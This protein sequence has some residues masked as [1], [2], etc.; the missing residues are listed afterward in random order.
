MSSPIAWYVF[1]HPINHLRRILASEKTYQAIGLDI[2]SHGQPDLFS[3]YYQGI[4]EV[5][6]P[7]A[8][9]MPPKMDIVSPEE[10]A[11]YSDVVARYYRYQDRLLGDVLA[12][13]S[14]DTIVIV[15]SDHGFQN[16]SGRP[17]QAPDIENSPGL[18]HRK[19]GIF[20]MAGAGG[21][22]G[23]PHTV[24]LLDISPT[25]VSLPRPPPAP[26]ITGHG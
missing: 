5:C 15:V 4:D 12:K 10:F 20:I 14:P 7:F 17:H 1:R 16:G 21:R 2:L 11:A 9:F 26:D 19:Y 3:I 23:Q 13:L 8:Q 6:H 25:V 22:K 24:P 18:W